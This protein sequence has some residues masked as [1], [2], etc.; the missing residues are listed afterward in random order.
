MIISQSS[1]VK[2]Y[3]SEI[4]RKMRYNVVGDTDPGWVLFLRDHRELLKASKTTTLEVLTEADMRIYEYRIREYVKYKT[5]VPELELAFRIIN[6]IGSDLEFNSSLQHV[7]IPSVASIKE[8]YQLY[9]TVSANDEN[10]SK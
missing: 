1:G 3:S 7:W 5:N 8:L 9:L 4:R 6:R 10:E 2:N